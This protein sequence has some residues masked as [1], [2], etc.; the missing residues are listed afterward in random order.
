MNTCNGPAVTGAL[1]WIPQESQTDRRKRP[2]ELA[3][4]SAW[5]SAVV[6]GLQTPLRHGPCSGAAQRP[7]EPAMVWRVV[8]AQVQAAEIAEEQS[9]PVDAP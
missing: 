2:A 5:P 8:T 1:V 4:S 9:A 7:V 6:A 3:L